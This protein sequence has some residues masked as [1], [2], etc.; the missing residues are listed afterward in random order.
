MINLFFALILIVFIILSARKLLW[1]LGMIIVLLPSYLWRFNILGLPTT[2]LELMIVIIFLLWLIKEKRYKKI[3]F[4]FQKN[5]TNKVPQVLRILLGLWIL[6]SLLALLTNFNW[7]T[8]GLWRAYFLEPLMFFLVFIYT[9]KDQK[10][11][12]VII[13]SLGLLLAWLFTVAMYQNFTDWNYIGA[14]NFPNVKRLTGPFTYPN[15]LSLLT[16]PLAAFFFGLWLYSKDKLFNWHYLLLF[17]FGLSL[18]IMTVSQGAIVAI[19]FSL[20]LA[21]ILAKKIRKWT[22]VIFTLFLSGLF[23]VATKINF[24]PNLNLESS[25]LDIRFNQWQ[26]TIRL[27][28]DNFFLGTGLNGY[29]KALAYYHQNDWLEIYLYPH[30]IFLN[31]WTEL[32]ILG[33]IIFIALI[34]YILYLLKKIFRAKNYLALALAMMWMV[35]LIHGLVDV[36]YFKNDLSVLFFI[37]LGLTFIVANNKKDVQT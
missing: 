34:I 36:P 32:G 30:N 9:V 4:S 25:S 15:A 24:N 18:A 37:M 14:Y 29:Q 12:R 1:G 26:E 5:N 10:D 31:F 17:V 28:A 20:F 19:A 35:W 13:N 7:N 16:A 6:A 22:R 21:L 2:F 33:L 3:N 8:L 27:L 23:I 11:W